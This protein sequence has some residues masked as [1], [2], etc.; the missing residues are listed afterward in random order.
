LKENKKNYKIQFSINSMLK[1][2]FEKN[3]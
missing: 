3:I 1:D 2:E